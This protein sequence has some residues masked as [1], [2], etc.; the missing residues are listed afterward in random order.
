MA[1][2][3]G[4]KSNSSSSTHA[5]F[6]LIILL[7]VSGACC[8]ESERKALLAVKS[9]LYNSD[10]WLSSWTGYDYC[11]WRGVAC[12]NITTHAINIIHFQ[13][14]G[15]SN[16]SE[17]AILFLIILLFS[18]KACSDDH[19]HAS[20]RINCLESERRALLA[21][22]SDL[23]NSEHWLSS[24]IDYDCCKWRG[25]ACDNTTNHVIRLDLHYP[26]DQY[27]SFPSKSKLPLSMG[28]FTS[29]IRLDVSDNGFFGRIPDALGNL[30]SLIR[31]DVSDNEFFGR[32]P[33]ALGNLTS[34]VYLNMRWNGFFGHIPD[35]L[36]NLTSLIHLDLSSNKFYECIPDVLG[37]LINLKELHLFDNNISCQIPENIGRLHKLS[38]F[39]A[40]GNNLNGQIPLSFGDL[41]NLKTLNLFS[42]EIPKWVGRSFPLLKILRLSS[43]SFHGAIPMSIVNLSL[44]QI[45]DL[46][47]NKLTGSIPSTIANFS[48]ML[49]KQNYGVSLHF[50][51]NYSISFGCPSCDYFSNGDMEYLLDDN[52]IITAKGSTNEYT[53]TLSAV[54]SIDLSNNELSGEIPKEITELHGL[55]F[56]NLSKNQLMGRIPENIGVMSE[57]ESLDLSMNRLTG[58]IPFSLSALNFL[59]S[60]NLSY[61]NL[62]GKIPTGGQLSTFND[63]TLYVG[64]EGLCGVPLPEC[65]TDDANHSPSQ[66]RENEEGDK[67]ETILNYTFIMMGFIVGFWAYF[68]MLIMKKSMK[69]T[70][71]QLVDKMYDWMYVQLRLK[72]AK[73]N[74][75]GALRVRVNYHLL[76]QYA[77]FPNKSLIHL[78]YLDLSENHITGGIPLSMGNLIYLEY[79]DLH[80]SNISGEIPPSM[81]NLIRLEYLDLS[82][83]YITGG[84][85]LSMGNLIC[86]ESL[87]LHD[88]NIIGEVPL[89]IGNLIS[90]EYLDLSRN[91]IIGEIASSMGYLTSLIRLDLS[92][93][94]FYGCIPSGL[95][96]LVNLEELR[97]FHN[98]ISCQIPESIGR[99]HNLMHFDA[100]ANNLMGQLPLSLGDLCNLT[101]LDLSLNNIGGELTNLLDGLS[102]C[103]QGSK[104]KYLQLQDNKLNGLA[105]S[106]LWQLAQLRTL[107]ISSNSLQGDITDA[108][109]SQ[110]TDLYY[111]NTSYNSLNYILSDD[112]IPPFNALWI[113]MSYCHLGTRFPSW[114]Q[115]QT[116][117][118]YLSFYLE[119]GLYENI[120]NW[121]S[122]FF[123][124]NSLIQLD[125]SSNN[126]SGQLPCSLSIVMDLSNNSF[127]GMIPLNYR[128]PEAVHI[129]LLS[130][131]YIN[132]C[133]PAFFCNLTML[134][135]LH[136]SNNYLSGEVPNCNGSYPISLHSLHMN[137]NNLSGPFPSVL[138]NYKELVTLDLGGNKFFGE[139]PNWVG[140]SFPLLKF[141]RLS[142][143]SFDHAI[144]TNIGNLTSLQVLDLSSNNLIGNV[145]SSITNFTSMVVKQNYSDQLNVT[146]SYL[147]PIVYS[148]L[149]RQY[150][151]HDPDPESHFRDNHHFSYYRENNSYGPPYVEFDR[152]YHFKDYILIT[153]KGST[154]EYTKVLSAVTSIDLSN[155]ELS[156]EIPQEITKLHGLYFLNLS[157]NYLSGRI[158][159]NIGVMIELESLDLS[160]NRLMGEIPFD[161]STL[162]FL[163]SLNL[164]YNNLSGKIPTGGQ[165]ST[166]N[167]STYV[168]NE[169]LCGVPLPTCPGDEVNHHSPSQEEDE[170][171]DE[172]LDRV[173]DYAIIV[174]GF[175]IGFWAYLGIIFIKKTTRITLFGMVDKMY[176]WMY[177]QLSLKFTKLKLKWQKKSL[178]P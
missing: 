170:E 22:K 132:G 119:L 157:N 61:N 118:R 56:L 45:L 177:V 63:S 137:K 28:N 7:F 160:M 57:L 134:R 11:K 17:H 49:V 76:V 96:N 38:D 85:P 13:R 89:S 122:D 82:G 129:L 73:L 123:L 104:L 161:L 46:S 87:Y 92:S 136:L 174:M 48:S 156:G 114:I 2:S 164:S 144:P 98:N 5:T 166:F 171:D 44:L 19:P 93:N 115:T 131:N 77:S 84:I 102:K 125:V 159:R 47:S 80:G 145:P 52:I 24:W 31:L 138:R 110:L 101:D 175:I 4:C 152:E 154:N 109:F 68:G 126:L 3:C 23:Y 53:T 65:P 64:N 149:S 130:N 100:S 35:A 176:D 105:P 50:S 74:L 62:S 14:K 51:G 43:N 133:L 40:S 8:L 169:G 117:L 143:N 142:S 37:N 124:E 172:K 9:G 168:G 72:I 75:G 79:L 1:N 108:H 81:G 162:N 32:I 33:D 178:S 25:V 42:G 71:F 16:F 88:N 147:T 121:F 30:T 155:N 140:R 54:A 55:C 91:H 173:L 148:A 59:E 158:P 141:L 120:P 83:N 12:D 90:L 112:W 135:V 99:L 127:E 139:I 146:D 27:A 165:L 103:P 70:L 78:E 66:I 128:N 69:V 107:D 167:D 29:L 111:L 95:G 10:H 36:G 94:E 113:D 15:C 151:Y 116:A 67:L 26:L 150:Y 39:D 60:L 106:N 21:I 41:C 58:E 34:L 86:L 97:L 20:K 153:A 163:G 6:F 18:T